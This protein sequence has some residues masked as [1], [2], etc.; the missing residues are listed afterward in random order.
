MGMSRHNYLILLISILAFLSITVTADQIFEHVPH[1]EDEAAYI[2]QAQVFAQN[3][4]T[5]PTPP[6]EDAFWSPFVV[7]YQDQ[8][9]GK[10]PPGWPFLL[11]FGMRLGMPWLVNAGLAVLTLVMLA[12][13]GQMIYGGLSGVW[14]AGLALVTPGFLVLSSSLL[15]H[16]ASLFW[17][18]LAFFALVHL[19]S[20]HPGQYYQFQIYSFLIGAGLGA[21]FVTRPFAAFGIALAIGPFLLFLLIQRAVPWWIIVWLLMGGG[22][23]S[24][25]LPLYWWQISG[26]PGF[27][28]YLLVWPYDRIGFGPDIGPEGYTLDI[29]LR[30]NTRLK[31]EALATGLFGWPGWLN[32]IFL[33]TPFLLHVANR[34]DWLWLGTIGGIIFVHIFYWA[35]GGVDGGFPRYYYDALPALL[36]LT[37]RG[38]QS[39]SQTLNRVYPRLAYIPLIAVGCLIL[40]NLTWSTPALL[41]AQ[42]GKYGITP[43]PLTA[44]KQA[45][46]TPPALILVQNVESWSDFAAPFAANSPTLNGPVVFA[47]DWNPTLTERVRQQFADYECWELQDENLE[48]CD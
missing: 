44:V 28:P 10:Y 41:S 19:S 38:I 37:V 32:L 30:I 5:V 45:N 22:L 29:A 20:L 33:P 9:F 13:I 27:N 40:Y 16:T 23:V 43:A 12:K 35:F 48:L 42:K 39:L 25:L 2:F 18:T 7:D 3:R 46:L 17:V 8:R 21:A 47:I 6:N 4:L 11:S 26:D 24:A 1:S 14:T 31:L 15:S 34:W 36:L